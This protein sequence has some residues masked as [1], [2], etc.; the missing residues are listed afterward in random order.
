MAIGFLVGAAA[1]A[2]GRV[3]EVFFGVRVEQQSLE[4]I[5]RPLTAEEAEADWRNEPAP[6]DLRDRLRPE[7]VRQAAHEWEQR[8]ADRTARRRERERTGARRATARAPDRAAGGTR[9]GWHGTAGMAS[10]TS[11]IA[12]HRLRRRDRTDHPHARRNRP[13]EP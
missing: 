9:R 11:A 8:I 12:E 3:A 6:Q 7:Q 2:L 4:N 5:A 1:M 13:D 10:R